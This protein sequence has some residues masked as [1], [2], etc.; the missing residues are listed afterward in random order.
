MN[1]SMSDAVNDRPCSRPEDLAGCL[2]YTPALARSSEMNRLMN[3]NQWR[4]R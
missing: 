3:Q 2:A 1:D 4:T